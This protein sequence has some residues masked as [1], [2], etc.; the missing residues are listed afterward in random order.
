VQLDNYDRKGPHYFE[1]F[2]RK[3]SDVEKR[4]RKIKYKAEETKKIQNGFVENNARNY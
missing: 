2:G 4:K 1:C 3:S